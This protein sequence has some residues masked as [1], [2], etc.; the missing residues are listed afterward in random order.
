LHRCGKYSLFVGRVVVG[1]GIEKDVSVSGFTVDSV[2]QLAIRFVV[3]VNIKD[4]KMACLHSELDVLMDTVQ[5]IKEVIQFG[6][7]CG[8]ITNVS[9]M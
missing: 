3:D 2:S 6:C 5:V 9:S 1:V 4:R 7:L 8:Q